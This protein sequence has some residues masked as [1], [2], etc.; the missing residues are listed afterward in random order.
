MDFS[1]NRCFCFVP[2]IACALMTGCSGG[3]S[4][5]DMQFNNYGAKAL[6]KYRNDTAVRN[7]ILVQCVGGSDAKVQMYHKDDSLDA[8]SLAIEAD[9]Y[10]GRNGCS[11][12]KK[13]GDGMS[14]IGDFGILLAYGIKPDPGTSVSYLRVTPDT[15]AIDGDNEY[16][17]M[18]VDA[19]EAGTRDGEEMYAYTPEYNY[20]L[21]L[22]YNQEREPGAGS[23]I[24]FHCKGAKPATGGCV[25]VDEEVMRRILTSVSPHDRICIYPLRVPVNNQ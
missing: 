16:Y 19:N 14:P 6:G 9:G 23:N 3:E 1:L 21:S 11:E 2:I 25:A 20:G 7:V 10:I 24:F 22:D 18:I 5:T 13:E 8:W 4:A 17:N 15:Y 12:A